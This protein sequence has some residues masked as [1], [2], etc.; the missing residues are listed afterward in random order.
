MIYNKE[1][2]NIMK[3][4]SYTIILIVLNIGIYVILFYYNSKYLRVLW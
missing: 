1:A 3:M 4:S 2:N